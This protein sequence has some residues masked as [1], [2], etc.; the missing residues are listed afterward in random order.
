[1]N[2]DRHTPEA[3]TGG[4]EEAACRDR[5]WAFA[6]QS[7][8]H[9]IV[10]LDA[11]GLVRWAGP[12]AVSIFGVPADELVGRPMDGLFL[13]EDREI[14][15]PAQELR[16][17]R[18]SGA[19]EDDRWMMRGDGSRFWASGMVVALRDGEGAAT[20]FVKIL[21]DLTDDKMQI[22]NLR[23]RTGA[24]SARDEDRR[25]AMAVL[26]HEL[27]N[28]LAALGMA[29]AMLHKAVDTADPRL[30]LPL[31]MLDRNLAFASRLV[32]DLDEV[33]RISRSK[34]DLHFECLSLHE[35]LQGAI[36]AANEAG[37]RER[38]ADIEL[39]V[40]PGSVEL[41]ADHLRMQQVFANL[42]GNAI[43]FSQ[44]GD[45]IWVTAMVEGPHV[46]V[47]VQDS[48]IGI[49]PD[50]LGSI[51]D[52]FTRAHAKASR[53]LGIG[54]AVVKS[55]VELHGGSVQARS[56]GVGKGSTFTVRL[57]LRQPSTGDL[58]PDPLAGS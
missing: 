45:R 24:L 36:S 32:D 11:E 34:L 37:D 46:V 12:G 16:V 33:A 51:F 5:I 42:V 43:K 38:A 17:A 27:R 31:G 53:G 49:A 2:G 28:L 8:E 54:L 44:H 52:M 56:E 25:R 41:E 58:P 50:M 55:I 10:L 30:R 6:R 4:G 15:I 1:M 14:G 13:P 26:S 21:R 47:R 7:R 39:L 9:A 3:T 22:E 20:G 29:N 57:P 35:L 23:N 48:G 18:S 19:S 40:P